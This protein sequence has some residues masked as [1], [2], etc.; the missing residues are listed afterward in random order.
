M[1]GSPEP[2]P[3]A[4]G[5]AVVGRGR[6]GRWRDQAVALGW[7]VVVWNL[8]WGD[9]NWANLV[10]GLLVGAAVL[11]FY[12]LPAVS[13]G[14]RLRPW[15]LLVFAGRFA[16]ELVSASL[17]VARIAVQP[18]YRPRGA[19]IAVRLRVPT[20]LN[21]ALT[22]EAVSLVPGTLILEVDRDS[23]TLYLHVMD[24]HG[25]GDLDVARDRTL[26]VERRIIRAVGSTTELRHLDVTSPE[27]G[28]RP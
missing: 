23:G 25:P 11:V 20:D 4:P 3:D 28:T 10:G 14:G 22:A 6:I 16:A 8:L 19:I 18:G 9:I 5:P 13:F 1:T 7:L 15:A 12:P 2:A 17:H 24:T 21:L 27:K 26:A